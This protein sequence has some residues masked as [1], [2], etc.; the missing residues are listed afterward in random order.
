MIEMKEVFTVPAPPDEV[1]A[2]LSDPHT[3]VECIDGAAIGDVHEDGSFDAAMT[4]KFSAMRVRF[5]AKAALE[6]EPDE[7]TGTMKAS[8]KDGQGGTRFS[9]TANF[10]VAPGPEPL[11]SRVT[12]TGAV[13]LKGKLASTIEGAANAVVKRMVGQFVD[14]LTLRCA[15]GSATI[16][17]PAPTLVQP[18]DTGRVDRAPEPETRTGVLVLHGVG[19]SPV[20]VRAWGEALAGP[21]TTVSIPRLTGHGSRWKDLYD[22]DSEDWIVDAATAFENLSAD[23]DRVFVLGISVGATLALRLAETRQDV[24]GV[25]AVNPL[26]G[27]LAKPRR[28]WTVWVRRT[29]P[30][31]LADVHRPGAV[32]VG[33]DRLPRSTVRSL[34]AFGDTVERDLAR[35]SAPVLLVSSRVDHVVSPADGDRVWA[36]LTRSDRDRLWCADSYHL[37]PLDLDASTLFARSREFAGLAPVRA[38]VANGAG[39]DV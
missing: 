33:Y 12:G 32:T 27:T 7:R 37:V 36:G 35:I 29:W 2:V 10:T 31:L 19:S 34:R 24:A 1:Y 4:V 39:P 22:T 20:A 38:G 8:G 5:N 17:A 9:C 6:L 23:H 3:V 15:S 14:E 30:L 18:R 13:D 25:V 26:L 16:A 28:A 21:G 11:T